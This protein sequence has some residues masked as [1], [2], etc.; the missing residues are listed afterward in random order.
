MRRES[1]LEFCKNC[2]VWFMTAPKLK[3][4]CSETCRKEMRGYQRKI[5]LQQRKEKDRTKE[6]HLTNIRRRSTAKL[7]DNKGKPYTKKEIDKILAKNRKRKWKFSSTELALEFGR[8]VSSI[9]QIRL[10]RK[11]RK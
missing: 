8:S 3:R 4:Y 5:Y 2:G 6:K 11:D 7:A 9:Q 1:H 10:R